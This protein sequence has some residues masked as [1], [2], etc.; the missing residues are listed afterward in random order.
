MGTAKHSENEWHAQFY[1]ETAA[2]VTKYG[3][4]LLELLASKQGE[5]IL[6]IGCGTGH[7]TKQIAD[8]GAGVVGID[9]SQSMVTKAKQLYPQCEFNVED[10]E[11]LPYRSQFDAVFSNAAL[12]WMKNAQAVSQSVYR[13]LKPGGRYIAELGGKGNVQTIINALYE[14]LA[15]HGI[16][17]EDVYYPWIFPSIGE[18]AT[19]LEK[20]GFTVSTMVLYERPTLLE[21][22]AKGLQDW[23]INFAG[24]FLQVV[25]NDQTK[26]AVIERATKIATPA[27]VRD[28]KWYA[29]YKRLRFIAIKP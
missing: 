10:A 25:H 26:H 12:H 2:Y 11:R 17:R 6:D 18:Y 22:G 24:D 23:I 1:D 14:A 20:A 16:Q 4:S 29:D 5:T 8:F 7:L 9:Y 27:I 3:E 13:A 19:I 15:E 28:G 21:N